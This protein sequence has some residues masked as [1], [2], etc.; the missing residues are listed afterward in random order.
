MPTCKDWLKR[1]KAGKDLLLIY[2]PLR[3]FIY[4]NIVYLVF[5]IFKVLYNDYKGKLTGYFGLNLPKKN[6]AGYKHPKTTNK[7]TSA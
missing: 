4:Y 1:F 6:F 2:I 5:N 7:I 3:I